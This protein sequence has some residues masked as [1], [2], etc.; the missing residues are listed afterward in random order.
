M[1]LVAQILPRINNATHS[2]DAAL[3]SLSGGS[4]GDVLANALVA[5]KNRG[6]K[7][8]VICETTNS[9]GSGFGILTSGGVTVITQHEDPTWNA[10]GI[11]HNKFFVF[12]YNGGAADSVWVW[13]GSW[14][15][16]Q[17]GT[18]QD[19]QNSIEIQDVALA[20]AYTLEFNQMWGSTSLTPSTASS[21][22][23]SDKSDI[24]PHNFVIG[25]VPVSCYFS[26]SD[27]TTSHICSTMS[28]AQA[29]IIGCI[30]TFT[31]SDIADTLV[32]KKNAGKKVRLT[33]DNSTDTGDQ[34]AFL[35]SSGVD[36]HLKGFSTGLLHHKYSVIDGD[37]SSG[38]TQ[39][40]TTGSHNWSSAAENSNDENEL[41]IHSQ[42]IA[43]LYLQEAVARY[44]EA[45]GTDS[46]H[47]VSG[48]PAFSINK[49]TINFDSINTGTS[50]VDSF[51]VTNTG[52]GAASLT[53]SSATSSSARFTISPSSASI[54]NGAS[55]TFT[56]TFSPTA[57]GTVNSNIVF[58]TNAAGSPDTETVQGFGIGVPAFSVN[59]TSISYDSVLVGS[60]KVDSFVVTNNGTASLNVSGVSSTNGVYTVTPTSATVGT[61]AS[62]TFK[63]TFQPTATGAAS[64]KVIFTFNATGSPDTLSVSGIGKGVVGFSTDSTQVRFG[65]VAVLS[66]L[67]D[68]VVVTNNGSLT[69]TIS[70]VS[71]SNSQYVVSPTSASVAV[72]AT[73]TFKITYSPTATGSTSSKIIFTSNYLGSPDTILTSGTGTGAP[74]YSSNKSSINYDS[75]NVG[76]S[77]VDSFTVTNTGNITMT[78]SSV[79]SSSGRYVVS[80]ASAS[81]AAS[82]SKTFTVTFSPT[83]VG[84]LSAS[85]VTTSNASNSP[86][87]V[88]LT[89]IG[90]GVPIY[91][92][93]KSSINYDSVNVGSSKQDSV[94]V[95][96]TGTAALSIT[97]AA[98]TNSQFTVSPTSATIAISGT[99]TF[100]VTYSPTATGS[101]NEN[102]IFTSNFSG[103][104]D[105]VSLKGVGK[106]VPGFNADK[107]SIAFDSVSVGSSKQ[108]SITVTNTG[109][110][111]VTVSSVT[112]SNA[113]FTVTPTSASILASGVKKFYVT[114]SPT[115]V[116]I[117][118][119][120]I[121]FTHSGAASPDTVSVQGIGRGVPHFSVNKSSIAF[122]SV[123]ISAAK[124]DSFLVTNTGTA[125]VGVFTVVSTNSQ[126]TATPSSAS[127]PVS[128]SQKFYVTY[129]P[130]ISGATSGA[131]QLMLNAD[132]LND[133]VAV[134]GAGNPIPIF[135]VDKKTVNL[136]TIG[137]GTT[138]I[139]SFVVSNPGTASLNITV[140]APSNSQ[141]TLN[142]QSASVNAGSSQSFVVSYTPSSATALSVTAL[143]FHNATGS[144][145]TETIIG[146]GK[147][148]P[149]FSVNHS[150]VSFDSVIVGQSKMDSVTVSNPGTAALSISSVTSSNPQFTVSPTSGSVSASGSKKFYLTYSPT[151]VGN[152][153][154]NFAFV[155]NF[156]GSPDTVTATGIGKGVPAFS[157]NKTFI[158]FDSVVIA[159][160][161][162]DSFAVTN[163][164]SSALS[165]S[166][167]ISSDTHFVIAPPN[168]TIAPS[169][170]QN[171]FVTFTP[172]S[173]GAHTA[174]V[175]FSHNAG[176]GSDTASVHGF[177]RFSV[178]ASPTVT[179]ASGWNMV[180]LP[181]VPPD[182]HTTAVFPTA[183]TTLFAYAG[184]YVQS[185]TFATGKGF[186]LKFPSGQ[187]PTLSGLRIVT[188]SVP[189]TAGWNMIGG[190]TEPVPTTSVSTTP[191]DMALSLF[192]TYNSG[193]SNVSSLTPGQGFWVKTNESGT[194]LLSAI[195]S[196]TPRT[197][198]RPPQ[199]LRNRL[200]ITDANGHTQT[201][202]FGEQP[203]EG[204]NLLQYELPPLPPADAFDVRFASNSSAQFYDAVPSKTVSFPLRLQLTKYPLEI[205]WE[206]STDKAH[207][208]ALHIANNGKTAV[209]QLSGS[210]SMHLSGNP[211]LT[212]AVGPLVDVPLVYSLAQNYPN[213]FNPTTTLS[214]G[215]PAKSFL[216]LTVYNTLGQEVATLID[217]VQDAGF[218]TAQW[219]ANASASGVY[220]YRL[221]AVD[222]A[223][224]SKSFTKINK[225]VLI[226]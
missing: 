34:Y 18:T 113:Q 156:S 138:K 55:K 44:Y 137:I 67:Q 167:V 3:Y 155:S 168:A 74:V 204:S 26:P 52:T 225:M 29:S 88:A 141:Y 51:V 174:S 179:L 101:L 224:A 190:I 49:S 27:H 188:T 191:P 108:D 54:S 121:V 4:Q 21:K 163:T 211:Q 218:H 151:A 172:D 5:A 102:L 107:A 41:I 45:G 194:L 132:A 206:I 94:S 61:S 78:I 92:V 66:S 81:L 120:N 72:S 77:K 43:N 171:F 30:Y 184:R 203:G 50:K 100:V 160:S 207:S 122:G 80:P 150:S 10:Q 33:M 84:S 105:S 23:G 217:G 109:S 145:D 15:P 59:K 9:G 221:Q 144:P 200:I 131:V 139:D 69:L 130:T 166:S 118:S 89:G 142:P 164:G 214:F 208:F 143:L 212:L 133:T 19:H 60:A 2:I 178:S 57:A 115:T 159:Q 210:G 76:S 64:G 182:V 104:P 83:A 197:V 195:S 126:F 128:G 170:S 71:S 7:V 220:F 68:S 202:T 169:Q 111:T 183:A 226:K 14:N 161:K 56:V 223:N 38:T 205:Q 110:G 136:D 112:S 85:I 17:S 103:S 22:F 157:V 119:S 193:Y 175:V 73:K 37:Q 96:N 31:R 32:A 134:S 219:F 187:S 117:S 13:G 48:T 152:A 140:V 47:V 20:G 6:V 36:V 125:A 40:V 216:R 198:A 11:M 146:M 189:V 181:I 39:Y 196:I 154:A 93:N 91:G 213:P 192:Y 79:A 53:I 199:P 8:R 153:S 16:T 176:S 129:T 106:G 186:W 114:Y 82:A 12:D 148:I 158:D 58:T 24:T 63:V 185:D 127:I 177:G 215:L 201:L 98:T 209:H 95:T 123:N 46:I 65:S 35:V 135:A 222:I 1:D 62:Q 28:Q 147:T 42:R 180:S 90:R 75:V 70:S 25:G 173:F 97:T 149:G 116:G 124:Q 87:T 99:Q 86:D 165:I 162:T